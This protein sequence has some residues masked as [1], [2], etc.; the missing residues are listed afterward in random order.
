MAALLVC[1]VAWLIPPSW[2]YVEPFNPDEDYRVPYAISEDYWHY[3]RFTRRA[4]GQGAIPIVGDS[5]VW[6]E[7]V[8][9]GG[10]LSDELNR[11]SGQARFANG[12]LN[13]LHPLAME[14]LT[15]HFGKGLRNSPVVLHCN[16]L[17]MSSPERDLQSGEE[18]SFNHPMLVRQFLEKV[19]VYKST[20][21]DRMATV[22]DRELPVRGWVRHLRLTY[23]N[24]QAPTTWSLEHPYDNPLAQITGRLPQPSDRARHRAVAWNERGIPQEDMPWVDLD[25]S[26]QWAGFRRVVE[27]LRRQGSRVFVVVGPF[28][29]H[30]LAD[31]SR[32]RYREIKRQ[33]ETYLAEHAIPHVAPDRF[34]ERRVRRR[35]SSVGRRLSPLGKPAVE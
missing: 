10:S 14:G 33:C 23:F 29:E 8:I 9:L 15:R 31:S 4:T 24:H 5:V 22:I 21:N 25:S 34:A 2:H 35:E 6:G 32:T 12:G 27:Y 16:L 11:L 30:L 13:G 26:L 3:D 7:Y 17:W 18:N 19:P 28:N 1:L 20:V